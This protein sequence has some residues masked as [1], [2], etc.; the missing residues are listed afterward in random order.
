[1]SRTITYPPTSSGGGTAAAAFQRNIFYPVQQSSLTAGIRGATAAIFATVFEVASDC[2]LQAVKFTAGGTSTGTFRCAIYGVT[3]TPDDMTGA[4]LLAES[5]ALAVPA[6]D[7]VGT[8]TFA[9]VALP[10]GQ[11]YAAIQFSAATQT[12]VPTAD[13]ASG[14]FTWRQ[15]ANQA[16]GAFPATAPTM[17]M[18]SADLPLLIVQVGAA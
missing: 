10:A 16:Y 9:D 15:Y 1:M 12:Y 6:A 8:A 14:L 7:E 18:D 17:S 2:V 3:V 13:S 11:Y 4:P 5:D